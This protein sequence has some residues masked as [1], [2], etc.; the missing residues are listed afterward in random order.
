MP[1]YKLA[2]RWH[3]YRA[4]TEG[5][6]APPTPW[7]GPGPNGGGFDGSAWR[8]PTTIVEPVYNERTGRLLGFTQETVPDA[9][10]LADWVRRA[11]EGAEVARPGGCAYETGLCSCHDGPGCPAKWRQPAGAS[12]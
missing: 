3:A 1:G 4:R 5:V 8:R 9:A 2:A 7:T 11:N 12:C 10:P 6:P